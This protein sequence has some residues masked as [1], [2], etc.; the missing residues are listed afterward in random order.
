MAKVLDLDGWTRFAK[1]SVE[2][3][4]RNLPPDGDWMPTALCERR[5]GGELIVG[6]VDVP[7]PAYPDVL[8]QIGADRPLRLVAIVLSSWMV[9]VTPEEAQT[10]GRGRAANDPNRTEVLVL[11]VADAT[12]EVWWRAL[13][14]RSKTQVALGEWE[15][16]SHAL[17]R[18]PGSLIAAIRQREDA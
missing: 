17:G 3:I 11:G 5:D 16:F 2:T 15:R 12:Q 4:G 9:T 8:N 6:L 10:A 14:L 13:I 18:Q 7:P 1:S